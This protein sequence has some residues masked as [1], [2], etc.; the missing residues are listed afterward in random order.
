MIMKKHVLLLLYLSVLHIASGQMSGF[1]TIPGDFPSIELA[2]STLNSQ[3]VGPGGIIF[4]V[5]ASHTE[6]FSTPIAGLITASGSFNNPVIFQKSGEGANPVITAATPGSG[7]MDFIICFSGSDY[8]TFDGIDLIE[9]VN[10]QT[11]SSQMEWGFA[12]LKNSGTDGAGNITV[13][14]CSI[15]LNPS[16]PA[17][18]AVYSNNHTP[19]SYAPLVVSDYSGTNSNNVFSGLSI[20]N[21]YNGFFFRGMEDDSPSAYYD[22][23]NEIG[24]GGANTISGLG[25]A[26]GTQSSYGIYCAYQKGIKIANNSFTGISANASGSL[27]VIG[28]YTA[29]NADADVFNNTISMTYLGTGAFYGIYNS[30]MG[31]AGTSNSVNFYGNN[32]INNSLPNYTGSNIGYIYISTGG[33]TANFHN[34]TISGN[35]A[36]SSSSTATGTIYYAYFSSTPTIP[37]TINIYENTISGNMRVQSVPGA[38]LTYLLYCSGN[39]NVLNEMNNTISNI[40][41]ASSGT[42]YALY[43]LYSGAA[44]NVHHNSIADIFNARGSVYG[45]YN[46]N[47]TGTGFFFNNEIR[48]INTNSISGKLYGIYQSS[49]T[50]QFHYNNFISELYAPQ[51]SG[52]PAIFG[53]YLSGAVQTGAFNN[54]IYLDA[55]SSVGSFGVAGIYTNSATVVD[56][57]NNLV[58]NNS[59]AGPLGRVV[60]YQRSSNSLSNYS[61]TSNNNNF[62]A[63]TPG[64]ANLIYYDGSAGDQ[65]LADYKSRVSPRDECSVT[66]NPP[67]LN[68]SISPYDLHIQESIPSQCESGGAT[69][70]YPVDILEDFEGNPR[71]PNEGYPVNEDQGIAVNAPDIGADE[72]GGTL[73]DITAPDISFTPLSNTAGL[74]DR[75]LTTTIQDATGIPTVGTGLPVLYWKINNGEYFPVTAVWTGG[76]SYTFTFGAGVSAGDVVSYYFVLQDM[77][78]PV[79]NV[80]ADPLSGAGG[81]T[82]D[83]PFCILPPSTPY[84]YSIVGSLAGTYTVG[85]GQN[86]P[87]LT[88]AIADL[89]TKEIVAPVTFM[90]MDSFYGNTES[91]PLVINT[92]PGMS[93]DRPVTIRPAEGMSVTVSGSSSTGI[94]ALYG[95]DNFIIDGSDDDGTGRNL[96]F[97]NT[98]PLTNSYVIGLFHNGTKGAQNNII[99]N[100]VVKAGNKSNSTW[101]IILNASGG[102]YDNTIIRNNQFLN[103]GTG[104]QF[105]GFPLGITNNGRIENNIFGSEDDAVTLGNTGLHVSNVDGLVIS[106]NIIMNIFTNANPKGIN[107]GIN[108]YNTLVTGN[109]ITGIIY[110]GTAGSGGKGID[111]NTG[112]LNSNLSVINNSISRISGDGWNNLG[113]GSVVGI[114]LL[115]T[116]GGVQLLFNSVSLSGMI[117]RPAAIADVSAAFYAAANVTDLDIR[118]NIFSNSLENYTGSAKAFS[119]FSEAPAGEFTKINYNNYHAGS[120]EGILGFLGIARTNIA[121]WRTAS[122]QDVN[123]TDQDPF[124]ISSSDLH[125]TNEN[126]NNKGLYLSYLPNDLSGALRTDPPDMGALEFGINPEVNTLNATGI[127]CESGTLNGLINPNGLTVSTF[128]D[129]GMDTSYGNT[130]EGSPSI[131]TGSS[132]VAISA[133]VGMPPLTTF[134]FR[135]RAVTSEGV[136]VFSNDQVLTTTATAIPLATTLEA[137]NEGIYTASLN[138]L[139]NAHCNPTTAMFEY[140]PTTSYGSIVNAVQGML[141]GDTTWQVGAEITGLEP[142]TLYHYRCIGQSDAGTTYGE[143]MIFTTL[144]PAPSPAGEISGPA[145]VCQS[146]SGHVYKVGPIQYA[147]AYIWTLPQGATITDGENSDSITVSFGNNAASGVLSVY[148]TGFGGD[149]ISSAKDITVIP[150]PIPV[151]SGPEVACVAS[152]YTY[153]TEPGMNDYAW[154]VSG[155]GEVLSGS[156]TGTITIRWTSTGDQAVSV[157]YSNAYGC[158][159]AGP[160]IKNIS[161]SNLPAPTINGSNIVCPGSDFSVYTTESGYHYYS[162]TVSDG[163]TLVSGQGTSQVEVN[164]TLAGEQVISVNYA[165]SSGCFAP[166]PAEIDV[167]VMSLPGSAGEISGKSSLC[168]GAFQ[169]CYSVAEIPGA[170]DYIWTLPAGAYISEGEHTNNIK[171]DFAG[172]PAPGIITVYGE[173]VCGQGILSPALFITVNPFPQAPAAYIDEFFM[174]HSSAPEGNQ[175]YLNGAL[176][177]GADSQDY[178][179]EEPGIYWT[180]VT[181]DG[182][183]SPESNPIEVLFTGIDESD[184]SNVIIYPVPNH[185]KFT[186]A[187]TT[188]REDHFSLFVYNSLGNRVY[189]NNDI[190]VN[191]K[192][193]LSVDLNNPSPGI[194]TTILQGRDRIIIRKVLVVQ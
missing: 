99:Q 141:T 171:V 163:G 88:A 103:A 55:S 123:S 145:T 41:V 93:P 77:V 53:I 122:L 169:V 95:A 48:N 80:S 106:G 126:I 60:A 167:D 194:Y 193:Q 121:E 91:F 165:N 176:I 116:T 154:T 81:Y 57:R 78:T 84:S 69:V 72:F 8:I 133:S 143:D 30:G 131:V 130:V 17:S 147:E 67:F 61:L 152:A 65:T 43:N 151:I 192:A 107:I 23:A 12:L 11:P 109:T 37:G 144:S 139:V 35:I 97:E 146:S 118:N 3:G 87:T 172:D 18:Y 71:Y 22:I 39:G 6:T 24:V 31:A 46:G 45:I 74:G 161:V 29:T 138:G 82:T 148:G 94:I 28:L 100:C 153:S 15:N 104:I 135:A 105:V 166:E 128:F 157:T 189:E 164:W 34:N 180:I 183:S 13:K 132:P 175:W 113:S 98:S 59:I 68:I 83:P 56:L 85:A 62:Y 178:Q 177:E 14:N 92:Y 32:I 173:N 185:G 40:T 149:G 184:P 124:F 54:T 120:P 134:H 150:L 21:T 155:G 191:G 136:T 129:F 174:L 27:Y 20:S 52:N 76:H 115:G 160:T 73:L 49:G 86:Y 70:N 188:T 181:L 190:W 47:G 137:S 186:V 9:N 19:G 156:G 64:P 159:A 44:K 127:N 90:L 5:A 101:A 111:V 75:V 89:Y 158:Q 187:M 1:R 96:T 108:S 114:R 119:I 36:G 33:V 110:A 182:C 140:G 63:G 117:S 66:E 112:L 125:P 79:P 42:T 4:N 2:I 26:S 170:L 58:V 50:N 16:N 142:V 168:A 38:G 51:A 25:N 7:S 102:D 10:N 179:A 162:W